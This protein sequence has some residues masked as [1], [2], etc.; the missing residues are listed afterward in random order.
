MKS[1][2]I[3]EVGVIALAIGSVDKVVYTYSLD[4]LRLENS[5]YIYNANNREVIIK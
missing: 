1:L 5:E 4:E 2:G 3:E